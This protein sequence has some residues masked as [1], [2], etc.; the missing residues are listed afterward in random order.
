MHMKH[1]PVV[2]AGILLSVSF[3]PTIASAETSLSHEY[4]S[5][6]TTWTNTGGPYI[7]NGWVSVSPGVTLTISPGTVVKF[8]SGSSL[9][10]AGTLHADGSLGDPV[11][12]TSIND[13]AASGD[14]NGDGTT[15]TPTPGD[16]GQV[17][18]SAGGVITVTHSVFRFGGRIWDHGWSDAGMLGNSGGDITVHDSDF[19]ESTYY[20][21]SGT[22]G[23]TTITHTIQ[24]KR[25]E[26]RQ[27]AYINLRVLTQLHP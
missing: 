16:W 25:I 18:T 24:K 20:Q 27:L 19:S 23:T 9:G 13:D 12:F 8:M 26:N 5:Q 22:G 2:I 14:T 4:I 15:T 17:H 21:I 6:D 11:I 1:I 3:A 7:L 10:V